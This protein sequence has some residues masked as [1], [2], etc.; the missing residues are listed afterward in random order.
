M[1]VELITDEGLLECEVLTEYS[2]ERA[3]FYCV[4]WHPKFNVYSIDTEDVFLVS[5]QQQWRLTSGQFPFFSVIEGV[6]SFETIVQCITAKVSSLSVSAAVSAFVTQIYQLASQGLLLIDQAPAVYVH[7]DFNH[8]DTYLEHE[9]NTVHLVNVSIL[10]ENVRLEWFASFRDEL[11]KNMYLSDEEISI[12]LVDDMLDPRIIDLSLRSHFFVFQISPERM[13]LSPCF[14]LTD[15]EYFLRFQRRLL[16]NQPI[17]QWLMM[18]RPNECHC[19][20]IAAEI[21]TLSI[22]GRIDRFIPQVTAKIIALIQQQLEH[23]DDKLLEYKLVSGEVESHLINV[24]LKT[25]GH[26]YPDIH[27]PIHIKNRATCIQVEGGLRVVKARQTVETLMPLVSPITGVIN[28]LTQLNKMQDKP[29]HIYRTG[30]FR[31]PLISLIKAE[32]RFVQICLGK[33]VSVEQSKASGLSEAI[34]RFCAI[35]QKELPLFK[36]SAIALRA[37]G[38]RYFCFQTLA[39]F[40][41]S[42]YSSFLLSKNAHQQ[43]EHAVKPYDGRAIHWLPS[44]SLTQEK[45]VYFPMSLGVSQ[46][47]FDD[48]QFGQW[49][50]NGCAAGNM[51]EEAILQ[52]LFEL[53]ERDA[54]AIWWYNR[55]HRAEFD[56]SRLDESRLAKISATLSPNHAHEIENNR[57]GKDDETGYEFWVLDLTHDLGVPVMAAI[58]KHSATAKFIMG[59]GCHLVSEVAAERALTELC[60]LQL[61]ADRHSAP[62]DFNAIID[63]DHLYPQSK[64]K[65]SPDRCEPQSA[66]KQAIK[67]LVCRLDTLGFEVCVFNYSQAAIPLKTVKILVPGLCHIWPQLANER[68][69]QLPVSLGWLDEALDENTINPHW[70]YI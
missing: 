31:A 53:I 61:I 39:P 12:V 43:D 16:V 65:P 64:V 4:Q 11:I 59:F 40:S 49:H 19:Y 70:L 26:F 48:T 50:S 57:D 58:G 67:M 20:P 60:Q 25:A 46:L 32:E 24:D 35:Y 30:F 9:V 21:S 18:I 42:Q 1:A 6:V 45:W 37:A 23:E 15:R 5:S 34:E 54:V 69:Y 8:N 68:L 36:C 55:L 10:P 28:H 13:W 51:V 14:K 38:L 29:I 17:R 33:G 44:W 41:E 3:P 56:L 52:G 66:L 22:E 27:T 47:P 62:F 63:G 2:T 7:A